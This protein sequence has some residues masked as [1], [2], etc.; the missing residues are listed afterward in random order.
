MVLGVN[1]RLE[2][3]EVDA[4]LRF[5][6]ARA[7]MAAGATLIRPAT[8]PLDEGVTFGPDVVVEPFVSITG[9]SSAAPSF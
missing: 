3:A 7:A 4:L 6:A 2:L 1:S 8:I 5:R 9:A